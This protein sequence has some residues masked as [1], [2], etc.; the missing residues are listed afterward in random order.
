MAVD[1]NLREIVHCGDRA[2][3]PGMSK[4]TR[5]G[6]SHWQSLSTKSLIPPPVQDQYVMQGMGF[7]GTPFGGWGWVVEWEPLSPV[8]RSS[9]STCRVLATDWQVRG[10]Y[11][12]LWYACWFCLCPCVFTP[13]G[14]TSTGLNVLAKNRRNCQVN[15][16]DS[17]LKVAKTR[18]QRFLRSKSVIDVAFITS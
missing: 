16:I 3:R 9:P 14:F 6:S 10:R 17:G 15:Y 12:C 8:M 11:R 18:F 5:T 7:G 2:L 1:S 4:L 13:R